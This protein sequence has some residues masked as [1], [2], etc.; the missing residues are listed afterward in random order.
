IGQLRALR[1]LRLTECSLSVI[2]SQIG[3]LDSCSYINLSGNNLESLPRELF[4]LP[5]LESLSLSQNRLT[6]LPVAPWSCT[7]LEQLT[8]DDNLL[9]ELPAG[10][11]SCINL[12]R[13]SVDA[14]GLTAFPAQLQSLPALTTLSLAYNDI[15][16]PGSALTEMAGLKDLSLSGNPLGRLP[17]D[18]HRCIAL[19]DL[20]AD[21]CELTAVPD[22]IVLCNEM[23]KLSLRHNQL[24]E[25]P[26]GLADMASMGSRSLRLNGNALDLSDLLPLA[27]RYTFQYT[28][29]PGQKYPV[30]NIDPQAPV[31]LYITPDSSSLYVDPGGDSENTYRWYFRDSLLEMGSSPE[32]VLPS[33]GAAWE[34][35]SCSIRNHAINGLVLTTETMPQPGR[36][37]P[38][39]SAVLAELAAANP[40]V[41]FPWNFDSLFFS[42]R[43]VTRG[44]R[45]RALNLRGFGIDSVPDSFYELPELTALDLRD[46]HINFDMMAQITEGFDDS[47]L[48]F[49]YVP[50]L[51]CPLDLDSAG[52]GLIIRS[53]RGGERYDWFRNDTFLTDNWKDTLPVNPDMLMRHTYHCE[54]YHKDWP[55]LVLTSVPDSTLG[56]SLVGLLRQRDS[57][58]LAALDAVNPSHSLWDLQRPLHDWEGLSLGTYRVTGLDLAGRGIEHLP[59]G[60]N[61][62]AGLR[63]L[64]LENNRLSFPELA[65]VQGVSFTDSISY[66]PQKPVTLWHTADSTALFVASQGSHASYQWYRGETALS[67]ETGDT[68][69][70]TPTDLADTLF[71]CR[72]RDS[73][74]PDLTLVSRR[75]STDE[76][77]I[78]A[79]MET[80]PAE[81]GPTVRS[82]SRGLTLT[83]W[84]PARLRWELYDVRGRS[85]AT[86]GGHSY[87]AGTQVILPPS[88][89]VRGIYLIVLRGENYRIRRRIM[90]H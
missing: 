2:P 62:L 73:R 82:T 43:I 27:E 72:I 1:K 24:K 33:H 48:D 11:F 25:L 29:Y 55:D 83:V 58:V 71:M 31:P 65:R 16:E 14:N 53:A 5:A 88:G 40:A 80:A 74:F 64:S 75:Q 30:N 12:L 78:T 4:Q 76:S 52:T 47:S 67:A 36:F 32:L 54:V 69:Q 21:N 68:L 19:E 89:M 39:D 44:N 66:A 50:Q 61:T 20:D 8:L 34:E 42:P 7:L 85:C 35:Y 18:I 60:M 56:D 26:E 63:S 59:E 79:L 15:T 81:R 22:N 23:Q 90:I 38:K 37:S 49:L 70:I 13:L 86:G 84:E 57:L 46:N 87:D 41:N 3:A 6:T 28:S 45:I 51:P 77:G 10:L 17:A 9:T